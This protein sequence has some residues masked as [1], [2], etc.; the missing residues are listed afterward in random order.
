MLDDDDDDSEQ[1]FIDMQHVVMEEL[2]N[3]QDDQ[4]AATASVPAR[5]RVRELPVEQEEQLIKRLIDGELTFNDYNQQIG[6]IV[7]DNIDDD[8]DVVAVDSNDDDDDE[9]GAAAAATTITTQAGSSRSFE[10]ELLQSRRDAIRGNLKGHKLDVDGKIQ[11]RRCV[12][13]I[14]LQGLMG[15]AN[16]C[17]ARG[18]I[19]LAEKVCF[20]II[21]Q[22]PLAPEPFLTL[23]QIHEGNAEKY[24]QFNLIAAHLNPGDLEQWVRIA[25]MSIE[26][27]NIKQAINCL[28]K[29]TKYHPTNI[30]AR[31]R[32]IELL[33]TL[34]EDKLAFRCFFS[35]LAH[36]PAENGEFLMSSAKKAATQLV[37][38]SNTAKAMEAIGMAY[39]KVPQLFATEDVNFYLELLISNGAYATV[40]QVLR[41]CAGVQV[42]LTEQTGPVV[43]GAAAAAATVVD[44]C[45][46]PN[47]II[48]G[49]WWSAS[50]PEEISFVLNR[51]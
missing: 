51:F 20:E 44:D 8:D 45:K 39:A 41:D 34:G 14:A 2:D 31:L 36:I 28:M 40:V 38:E 15:E 47:E 10:Q 12:L 42:M 27:G 50:E 3:E 33:E 9:E 32:R 43:K 4:P 18:Q 22:V 29:A 49:E 11:R 16:L 5:I 1:Q 25:Q 17:Y 30:D 21:R 24:L 19:E 23:A 7:D 26:Q 35:M 6:Q 37:K 13:P 46:I 48:L